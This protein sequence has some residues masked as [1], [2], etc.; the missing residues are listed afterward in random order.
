MNAFIEAGGVSMP[1]KIGLES[2]E[3]IIEARLSN[4]VGSSE[5]IDIFC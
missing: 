1:S 2:C 3:A 4:S 5:A